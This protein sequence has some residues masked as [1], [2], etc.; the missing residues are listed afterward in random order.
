MTRLIIWGAGTL[1]ARVGAGWT[2]GAVL[3]FTAGERRH[4]H[5]RSL[6][7]APATGAPAAILA[8][9]DAL[10]LAL[11]GHQAQHEAVALLRTAGVRPPHR[12]VLISSVGYYEPAGSEVDEATP[13]GTT[14]RARNIAAAEADFHAWAGAGGVVLRMG[15][16]YGPERGPFTALQRKRAVPHKPALSTLSLIHYYDAA[17]ATLAALQREDAA[18]AYVCVTPPCPTRAEFY[19]AACARLGLPA[20]HFPDET[21]HPTVYDV[22]LLR[23][24]LLPAPAFPDWRDTL[25]IVN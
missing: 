24:D 25:T 19:T 5:L 10:L 6:G 16:L 23:R 4:A 21:G 11:P 9:D 17:A 15:G 12:A 20:P 2:A 1:G 18:P 3:G 13:A 14:R 8:P 22:T 7:I